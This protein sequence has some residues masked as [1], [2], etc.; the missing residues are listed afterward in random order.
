M[1][2][3]RRRQE[4]QTRVVDDSLYFSTLPKDHVMMEYKDEDLKQFPQ[5]PQSPTSPGQYPDSCQHG[6]PKT[7]YPGSAY[8]TNIRTINHQHVYESPQLQ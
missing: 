7:P 5:F 6:D 2:S 1:I 4:V 3:S 8:P